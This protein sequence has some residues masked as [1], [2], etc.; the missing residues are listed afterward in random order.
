MN[1]K[2]STSCPGVA[3]IECR[4]LTIPFRQVFRHASAARDKASTVWVKAVGVDGR[5]G[6]G[7]GCPRE[8]V[9]GESLQSAVAFVDRHSDDVAGVRDLDSLK[10]WMVGHAAEIDRNPAAWCALELALLDLLSRQA[11]VPVEDFLGAPRLRAQYDYTAVIGVGSAE[12]CAAMVTQYQR[13]GMT[14]Y[15][16]KLSGDIVADRRNLDVLLAAQPRRVRADAN[17]LWTEL[18]PA[19]DYLERLGYSFFAI[20]EPLPAGRYD[21]MAALARSLDT[22][23]ILDES[24]VRVEQLEHLAANPAQWIVNVRV[25]KMGGLLRSLAFI[26]RCLARGIPVVVGAQVGETSLLTRAALTTATAARDHLLAQE[27][28]FGTYLLESDPCEPELRFGEKGRLDIRPY[29]QADR[30]GFGL[31]VK[32]D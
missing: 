22:R 12:Q 5:I 16:I 21:L 1:A 8:Y 27:G 25:S 15:K 3:S 20:E 23:I 9:T 32:P 13:M 29:A 10:R 7:E 28:A 17:N 19:Q 24:A 11:C 6:Y 31:Q 30:H 18:E 14:D 26:E 2:S 4:E